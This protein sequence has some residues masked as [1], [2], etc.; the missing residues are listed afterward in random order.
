MQKCWTT[1]PRQHPQR[2]PHLADFD[3]DSSSESPSDDEH[4]DG[5]ATRVRPIQHRKTS[6][7][8]DRARNPVTYRDYTA[9]RYTPKSKLSDLRRQSTRKRLSLPRPEEVYVTTMDED[10]QQ[11]FIALFYWR[12]KVIETHFSAWK[13]VAL[14]LR[15]SAKQ[16]HR[17]TR[18][19]KPLSTSYDLGGLPPPRRN[20][21]LK[22]HTGRSSAEEMENNRSNN[23]SSPEY[24]KASR[25]TELTQDGIDERNVKRG[26]NSTTKEIPFDT[27]S[28]E[29]RRQFKT[30]LRSIYCCFSQWKCN[31]DQSRNKR[32][33]QLVQATDF[34]RQKQLKTF[35]R[36]WKCGSEIYQLKRQRLEDTKVLELHS[37][38][39]PQAPA[40]GTEISSR[41]C[42]SCETRALE[43]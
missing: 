28:E 22:R 11:M 20:L 12:R 32:V 29:K 38:E 15:R 43:M 1:S 19:R 7:R 27:H 8:V 40:F 30:E 3:V 41:R 33:L 26:N 14:G 24:L 17:H 23:L 6:G 25:T 5:V 37:E 4:A 36:T 31:V 9:S 34:R 21:I 10:D 42:R 39:K 18:P 2:Y 35:I 13:W 16:I